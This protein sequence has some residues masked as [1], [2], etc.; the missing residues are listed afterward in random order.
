M[1]E[2]KSSINNLALAFLA[3]IIIPGGG[4]LYLGKKYRGIISFIIVTTFSLI[5][6]MLLGSYFVPRGELSNPE[7]FGALKILSVF[8]EGFNGLVFWISVFLF[9]GFQAPPEFDEIGGTYILVAGILN[10]LIIFD[11]Y[12][13]VKGKKS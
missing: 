7:L 2:Q 4:Y 3:G 12:D 11:N 8:I 13:I 6:F 9:S 10:I 1:Q 5:G